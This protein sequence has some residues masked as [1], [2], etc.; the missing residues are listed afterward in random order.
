MFG[1]SFAELLLALIVAL[2]VLG[3]SDF[4]TAIKAV[5]EAFSKLQEWY[6]S[7]LHYLE[8][9]LDPE[10][11]GKELVGH[12]IDQNGKLQKTYNLDLIKPDL[13]Q[14]INSEETMD[15]KGSPPSNNKL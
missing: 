3:P 8:T 1:F 11:K 13:K 5:R 2:L 4:L 12:I 6:Q 15:I 9:E 10:R 14:S 7:Y